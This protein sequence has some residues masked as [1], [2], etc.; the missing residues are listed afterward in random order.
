MSLNVK[1]RQLKAFSLAVELGSFKAAADRLAVTQPSFSALIKELE[2][3][4][5]VQLFDRTARGSVL[6]P[7]GQAFHTDVSGALERL[8][9]AYR[10][11]KEVGLGVRGTLSL[12]A[13]PSLAAGLVTER[14]GEFRRAHPGVRIL[15]RERKNSGLLEAVRTGECELGIGSMWRD[16]PG[17]EFRPLFSD[18][19]MFVVPR[20]HPMEAL[21][22]TWKCADLFD[23]ILMTAGPTE[24][25]LRVSQVTRPPAF[26]VEHLATA[27]AMVRHGLGISILPESSLATLNMDGL[28]GLPVQGRLA[29]RPL[30]LVVRQGARLG[31]PARAFAALL[32]AATP[33]APPPPKTKGMRRPSTPG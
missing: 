6:T 26:E 4:V 18:R 12:A 13:L 14:L 29:S 7:A 31:A 9:E 10:H 32:A 19:M 20:G 1:Y 11:V 8:E 25:A 23:L 15:M 17:L 28:V 30:G 16:E 33:T 22:P 27:A 24:H 3:D 5:D 2:R 21:Q